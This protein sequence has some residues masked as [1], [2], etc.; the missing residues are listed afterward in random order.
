[1]DPNEP[2][3]TPPLVTPDGTPISPI[4]PVIGSATTEP[5]PFTPIHD[6]V[7]ALE[8][9]VRDLRTGLIITAAIAVAALILVLV[10]GGLYLTQRSA[11][12]NLQ[13]Q[14]TADDTERARVDSQLRA[15]QCTELQA[16]RGTNSTPARNAFPNGAGP[17]DALYDQLAIAASA[18][19]CDAG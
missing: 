15:S 8:E 5:P 12:H 1:M 17:Y 4:D 2:S 11:I 13:T 19:N 16:I 9:T 6:R 14:Q 18:L 7:T 10:T 3:I